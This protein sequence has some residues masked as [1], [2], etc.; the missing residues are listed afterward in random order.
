[1]KQEAE[2]LIPT[3]KSVTKLLA[4]RAAAGWRL[5]HMAGDSNIMVFVFGQSPQPTTEQLLAERDAQG[6]GEP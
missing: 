2:I 6:L 5:D 4:Q 1:M 3:P